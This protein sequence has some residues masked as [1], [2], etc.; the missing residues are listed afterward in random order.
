MGVNTAVPVRKLRN[1]NLV[2]VDWKRPL[3]VF[4]GLS[5]VFFATL[6]PLVQHPLCARYAIYSGVFLCDWHVN[7]KY[8]G[9][10]IPSPCSTSN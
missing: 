9:L 5:W 8:K 7:L 2:A 3:Q 1:D 4:R 6:L 10:G